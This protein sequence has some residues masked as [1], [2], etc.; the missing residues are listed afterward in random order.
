M[1]AESP[2]PLQVIRLF[3]SASLGSESKAWP[4][5][6]ESLNHLEIISDGTIRLPD[7]DGE[8]LEELSLKLEAFSST[9]DEDR[10][11]SNAANA[12]DAIQLIFGTEYLQP[13][14]ALVTVVDS[15]QTIG[16]EDSYFLYLL[17]YS[18]LCASERKLDCAESSSHVVTVV[19]EN[20]RLSKDSF[21]PNSVLKETVFTNCVFYDTIVR[22]VTFDNCTF[23]GCV[24]INADLN[25][26]IFSRCEA[27]NIK[28]LTPHISGVSFIDS[29]FAFEEGNVWAGGTSKVLNSNLKDVYF[30]GLGETAG[31]IIQNSE[32]SGRISGVSLSAL[33]DP[34]GQQ[35]A[36]VDLSNASLDD[37]RF[38]GVD[39]CSVKL[40]SEYQAAIIDNWVQLSSQL[41]SEV[42]QD[43]VH[44]DTNKA[45]VARNLADLWNRDLENT[46]DPSRKSRFAH[47]LVGKVLESRT[48]N[49]AIAL[50]TYYDKA[51]SSS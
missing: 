1:E 26:V 3:I 5:I 29:Q 28:F 22:D 46:C 13:N 14:E 47:E 7:K 6:I 19:N 2:H 17:E 48:D 45:S 9:N 49:Y 37:C 42:A 34:T 23:D 21:E 16:T 18:S 44:N 20:Q 15:L 40:G 4:L 51:L 27:K 38:W 50:K 8:A 31:T 24:F 12:Y 36:K 11:M 39:M 32:I 10:E 35:M 33:A 30:Y 41:L 25:N 43:A